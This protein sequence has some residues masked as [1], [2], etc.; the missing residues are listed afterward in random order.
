[1]HTGHER[2]WRAIR[3]RHNGPGRPSHSADDGA[4]LGAARS[5]L[6]RRH[7]G[8]AQVQ[9]VCASAGPAHRRGRRS[10]PAPPPARSGSAGPRPPATTAT[11]APGRRDRATGS[12]ARPAGAARTVPAASRVTALDVGVGVR[13]ARPGRP[14][15][16]SARRPTRSR[17]RWVLMCRTAIAASHGRKL[18][19]SRSIRSCRTARSM[20]SCTTSSTSGSPPSARR[21]M[22]VHQGQV[23]R[24]ELVQRSAVA[25]LRGDD[26]GSLVRTGGSHLPV[27]VGAVGDSG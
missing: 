1:M 3:L 7:D 11:A 27:A 13:A 5:G 6:Q 2:V 22:R 4:E 15:R 23:R 8:T 10:P 18:S 21:T 26:E 24:D 14:A 16:P 19:G 20:T 12:P 17:C 9:L 25:G